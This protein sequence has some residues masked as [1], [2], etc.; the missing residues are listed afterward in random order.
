MFA[1]NYVRNTGEIGVYL[2]KHVRITDVDMES[3]SKGV[4]KNHKNRLRG[5]LK[6]HKT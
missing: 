2:R 4:L 3:D 5:M 6:N 1:A